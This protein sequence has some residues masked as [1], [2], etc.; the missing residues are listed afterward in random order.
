MDAT[1]TGRERVSRMFERRDHDRVPRHESFWPDTIRRW[2]AEGLDG[3]ALTVLLMLDN[4]FQGLC[5]CSPRPYP[6]QDETI[7]EDEQTVTVRNDYGAVRRQWKDRSGTPEHF[8]FGCDTPQAWKRQYKPA[9]LSAGPFIDFEDMARAYAQGRREQNWC[10]LTAVEA[11]EFTRQLM[12]DEITMI[13]MATDP[14][15]V[16]DVATTHTD[17]VLRSFDDALARGFDP[18]GVWV[19]GDM[20]FNHSTFCSPQMYRD[21]IWPCHKRLAAWTHEHGMKFIYH[22]DGDV[23]GVIDLYLEAGFDCLQPLEAK[24]KMDV[25]DLCPRYGD[26]LACFGNIDVMVMAAGDR[27]WIEQEIASKFAAGKATRGYVYHSDHSVPP[28]VSFGTYKVIIELVERY[29]WYNA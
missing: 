14:E 19:Y 1:M 27:E 4:D 16:I 15:W 11:F 13:A 6:G 29:G 26:R 17:L 23:N 8:G 18:D 22:T 20:A 25:R 7:A 12:G 2:Q 3:D 5:W 10:H 28:L 24:A 9:L 21:L